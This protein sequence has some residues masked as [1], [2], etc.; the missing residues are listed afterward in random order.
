MDGSGKYVDRRSH[1]TSCGLCPPG[2]SSTALQDE[3]G[4][5]AASTC[6]PFRGIDCP[7]DEVS[8]VGS[9]ISACSG[10]RNL[11]VRA[12][13]TRTTRW[14]WLPASE[15]KT[16]N[17]YGLE[18]VDV[19][20]GLWSLCCRCV[21]GFSQPQSFSTSCEPCPKG[22]KSESAGSETPP[23]CIMCLE[24]AQGHVGAGSPMLQDLRC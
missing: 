18:E 12:L 1:A 4:G 14:V 6:C 10:G 11:L 17:V 13:C 23:V 2:T 3:A 15:N 20:G 16:H 21:A 9:G 22:T 8:D 5:H 19:K 24:V 7:F